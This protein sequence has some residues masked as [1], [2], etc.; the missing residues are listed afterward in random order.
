MI[1]ITADRLFTPRD[2]IAQP[3]LLIEDGRITEVSSLAH[4]ARPTGA[5]HM[6]FSSAILAAGFV[7][8]HIHG[9][10]GHDVMQSD[11]S[12][13]AAIAKLLA[14]HGVCSYFPT[15][16]TAPEDATLHAL[17]LLATA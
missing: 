16:V 11:P 10:A 9:G 14:R 8:I 3:L 4:R 7:D 12:G 17:D 13:L 15:T 1:A 6:D 2:I 5:R